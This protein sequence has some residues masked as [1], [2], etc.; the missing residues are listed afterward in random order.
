M[1]LFR[2]YVKPGPGVSVANMVKSLQNPQERLK[3]ES[4]EIDD[5]EI[6]DVID[7]QMPIYL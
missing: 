1:C 3:W 5:L 6:I 7:G 4:D 2:G